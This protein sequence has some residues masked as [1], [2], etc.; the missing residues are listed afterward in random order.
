MIIH[1]TTWCTYCNKLLPVWFLMTWRKYKDS[2]FFMLKKYIVSFMSRSNFN[3]LDK[4][5]LTIDYNSILL[6]LSFLIWHLIFFCSIIT[7]W[8]FFLL[9]SLF[10]VFLTLLECKLHPAYFFAAISH[11]VWKHVECINVFKMQ[12]LNEWAWC[13]EKHWE[14][15]HWNVNNV[16]FE[17]WNYR[18]F[19]FLFMFFTQDFP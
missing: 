17:W 11:N 16:Q 4:P 18:P 7:P 9:V 8:K 1:H 13:S 12:L 5:S 2:I 19:Y 3:P 10:I 14:E 6:P 15:L